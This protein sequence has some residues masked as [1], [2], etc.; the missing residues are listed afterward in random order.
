MFE[1][2]RHKKNALSVYFYKGWRKEVKEG[3]KEKQMRPQIHRLLI[4]GAKKYIAFFLE[5]TY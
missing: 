3:K 1:S 5:P 4:R 2:I